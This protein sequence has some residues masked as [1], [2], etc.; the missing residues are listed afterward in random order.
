VSFLTDARDD[1]L[2][3][4][5]RNLQ[6]SDLPKSFFTSSVRSDDVCNSSTIGIESQVDQHDSAR[7]DKAVPSASLCPNSSRSDHLIYKSPLYCQTIYY[8]ADSSWRLTV[9]SVDGD[10]LGWS[11][12][13]WSLAILTLIAQQLGSPYMGIPPVHAT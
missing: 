6:S 8:H 4:I 11:S 10:S 5:R 13:A 12:Q 1:Q 3:D 9:A 2:L 7:Q